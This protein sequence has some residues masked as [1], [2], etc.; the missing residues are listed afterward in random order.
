M[1]RGSASL[2]MENV[3]VSGSSLIGPADGIHSDTSES[4]FTRV[5]LILPSGLEESAEGAGV[6]GVVGL[7]G[8]GDDGRCWPI[9]RA[10]G[11]RLSAVCDVIL[12]SSSI[13]LTG[14]TGSATGRLRDGRR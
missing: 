13:T 2:G 3:S 1:R 6:A 5:I 11:R 12:P 9:N 4:L 7:G 8:G 14:L 10:Y